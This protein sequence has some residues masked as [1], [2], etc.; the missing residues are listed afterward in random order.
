M[1]DAMGT[2]KE[3]QHNRALSSLRNAT[4]ETEERLRGDLAKLGIRAYQPSDSDNAL[5]DKSVKGYSGSAADAINKRLLIALQSGDRK[6]LDHLINT[7]SDGKVRDAVMDRNKD[8]GVWEFAFWSCSLAAFVHEP[9]TVSKILG[10]VAQYSTQDAADVL[11]H[12]G[13]IARVLHGGQSLDAAADG[14]DSVVIEITSSV[15]RYSSGRD[16]VRIV[17]FVGDN[18]TKMTRPEILDIARKLGKR[19]VTNFLSG[20]DLT[21][22]WFLRVT[23]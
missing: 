22:N 19:D 10:S 13:N 18:A 21:L 9:S 3:V 16:A 1:V 11:H 6:V 14:T 20:T 4:R 17:E 5:I 15:S 8:T 23:D 12:I 2:E 7:V